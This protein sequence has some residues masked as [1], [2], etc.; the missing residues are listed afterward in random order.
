M[1]TYW[2]RLLTG[3][4]SNVTLVVY[5]LLP[6]DVHNNVYNVYNL[7]WKMPDVD[8]YGYH[9]LVRVLRSQ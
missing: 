2:Y 8:V 5:T 4:Q 7:F 6:N 3:K 1:I 9:S